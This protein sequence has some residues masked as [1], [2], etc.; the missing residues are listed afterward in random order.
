[1]RDLQSESSLAS[2][3]TA[4]VW[5]AWWPLLGIVVNTVNDGAS[6]ECLGIQLVPSYISL[7]RR[8]SGDTR[9]TDNFIQLRY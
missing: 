7:S 8:Y 6:Y 3:M 9:L 4:D 2:V 1:M 5:H